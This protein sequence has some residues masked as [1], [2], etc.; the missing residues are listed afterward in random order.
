MQVRSSVRGSGA[1]P[2]LGF[3]LFALLTLAPS[4]PALALIT[5]GT[6]N[7]P[8]D[9]AQWPPG[10]AAVF[11]AKARVAYWEGPPFG[12][13]E[14]HAECRGDAQTLTAVLTDFAKLD[15]KNKRIVLH[16][17]YSHS[18]WLNPNREPDKEKEARIDWT[19]VVWQAKNWERLRKFPAELRGPALENAAQGP[20]ARLDVYTGGNVRWEAVRVPEGLMVDDQRL[21]AH[22][23]QVSD[24]VV[25]EGHLIDHAT[26]KPL[27]GKVRLESYESLKTGGY[28]YEKVAETTADASGRWVLKNAPTGRHR[29]VASAKG[30]VSRVVGYG[31]AD[32]QPRWQKFDCRLAVAVVV[33]GRV[34][35]DAGRPLADVDVRLNDVTTGDDD[36]RYDAADDFRVTTDDDGRFQFAQAPRGTASVRVHKPG[37]VRPGLGAKIETPAEGLA[38]QMMKS[39]Q[40]VVTVAFVD[41]A[42][43]DGYVV[44]IAAEGGEKIGSWGGSGNI[45]A[46]NQITFR[47]VPPGRYVLHG[48]PN[49]G[50]DDQQTKSVTVEL[51]GGET[52]QLELEAK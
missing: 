7:E 21:A 36:G 34:T 10:A 42:R 25:L 50:G 26:Q 14:W 39:A 22:G 13:G 12:G 41:A 16:D 46:K 48:R 4:A 49:P 18:F 3:F 51:K 52:T 47:D 23:F 6:G 17:G 19:F 37:Y 11:N 33:A 20:P 5:G 38:L 43:P 8:I 45:D 27:V 35:D 2:L 31:P 29:V 24:G 32:S 9:N 40:L 15:V 44:N 28:R 1:G 30:H